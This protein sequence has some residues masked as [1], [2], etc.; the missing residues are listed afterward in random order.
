M[1]FPLHRDD[2]QKSVQRETAHSMQMIGSQP[3]LHLVAFLTHP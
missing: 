1:S 3:E 2:P